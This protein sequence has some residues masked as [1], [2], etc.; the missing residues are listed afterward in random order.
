MPSRRCPILGCGF[1]LCHPFGK[2]KAGSERSE[3]SPPRTL[4]GPRCARND[5]RKKEMNDITKN[6]F[7]LMIP[8]ATS[9]SSAVTV[10]A[11]FDRKPI[12]TVATADAAAV[13]HALKT[14][15][16]L[17]R[18]RDAWLPAVKRI[19]ILEK[20]VALMKERAEFLAVGAARA[21]G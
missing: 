4:S 9:K 8:G 6:Q 3:G 19:E 5:T 10:H 2:L 7:G 18:N 20:V 11:P 13:E 16:G 21:G 15:H 14:A 17:Y 12:G 1:S